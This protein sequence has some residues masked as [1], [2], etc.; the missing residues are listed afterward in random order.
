MMKKYW[1]IQLTIMLLTTFNAAAEDLKSGSWRFELKTANATIP[2]IAELN[3]NKDGVSGNI[4]NGGEIIPLENIIYNKNK[5][6]I[7]IQTYETSMELVQESPT[8]LKGSWIRHNKVPKMFLPI[9]ATYG[10]TD[11]FPGKKEQAF[12]NLTGK[13]AIELS[14][15]ENKKNPGIAVFNQKGNHLSGSILTA[16]GDYRYMEGYV[17]GNHFEAASFDGMYNYI[18]KGK[19]L[20][21]QLQAAILSTHITHIK[22]KRD[23][24]ARLPDAYKA[25][26][27][28]APL[29][30]TFPDLK[31]KQVSLTDEHFKNRPV[32]VQFF[33][34]WC[35]N[36]I[37][38]MNYLIPWYT[39][40][41]KRGIE[42]IALA[43]ERS[44]NEKEARI[45]L[46][47]VESKNKLPYALLIA[48]STSSD[49]PMEKISGLKNFISFPT[50]I[51][52]N[53][54]HEVVKIHAGF[55]GPSTGEYFEKWKAEFNQ[56]I[57]GLLK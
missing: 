42:V 44:V 3:F 38:E 31:G 32:V 5:L 47:K 22:G 4:Y 15:E 49:A 51:F 9:V 29:N 18:F 30:F 54:K 48:G 52:L 11:R 24:N 41:K 13:W 43:F 1:L 8:S 55:S 53:K 28:E 50:L 33:G 23:D 12:A 34:S 26:Q 14:D 45:Q 2:F 21:D 46:Q 57:D 37:D 6:L 25:T 27:M 16:T 56:T 39:K 20:G 17:S 7:P 35:P 40:N 36:C 19:L 10:E